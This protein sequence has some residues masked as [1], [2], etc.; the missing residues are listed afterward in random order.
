MFT[1][2]ILLLALLLN[3]CISPAVDVR[4]EIH[5]YTKGTVTINMNSGTSVEAE[6]EQ[7]TDAALKAALK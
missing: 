6:I 7:K 3:G 5:V 4:K 2:I 1:W